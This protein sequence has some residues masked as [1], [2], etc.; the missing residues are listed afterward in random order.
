M[1]LLYEND[2]I[3]GKKVKVTTAEIAELSGIDRHNIQCALFH[4]AKNEYGYFR[5]YKPDNKGYTTK[6]AYKYALTKKGIEIYKRYCWNVVTGYSLDLRLFKKRKMP[7]FDNNRDFGTHRPFNVWSKDIT[8]D[9]ILNYMR[10]TKAGKEELGNK[11]NSGMC[12]K[13]WQQDI[14]SNETI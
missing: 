1:K 12:D 7:N 6:K 4:Y 3:V 9:D 13:I 2:I 14:T 10:I 5:R 11:I 8:A